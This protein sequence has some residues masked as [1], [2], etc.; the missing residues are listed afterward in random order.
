MKLFDKLKNVYDKL[1][2][3]ESRLIYRLRCDS[4]VTDDKKYFDEYI[5]R[6]PERE[7]LE[8]APKDNA[9]IFGCGH[10][11]KI[12]ANTFNK[13][14][15]AFAD[16]NKKLYSEKMW[17]LPVISPNELPGDATVYLAV[18]WH[19]E[20]IKTQ[21]LSLGIRE[22]NIINV[23]QVLV[24]MANRQYFDLKEFPHSEDEVFADIGCLNGD[25]SRN[26]IEWAKG[27]YKHIYCFEP[28][29]KNARDCENKLSDLIGE[30]KVTVINKA[31]AE[32]NGVASFCVCSN[33]TSGIGDGDIKVETVTIDETLLGKGVTFLKMDIEGGEYNALLGAK[34]LISKEH[35]KLAI[36]VYHLPE[37]I[38]DL[39]ALILDYYPGY[40]FYIRHYSP[41]DSETILYA[42]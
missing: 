10:Y 27:N 13:N 25:T 34:E 21:L 2:D 42:F 16:N 37:D 12:I 7:F 39:P 19:F 3:E 14:W 24:D 5:K 30:D 17:G 23:G 32:K 8:N 28:D 9:Y 22:E 15:R 35:P 31:V 4:S 40:K 26:F 6:L 29:P 41:F 11:G 33:G 1:Q 18:K 36:S 38:Y 20:E